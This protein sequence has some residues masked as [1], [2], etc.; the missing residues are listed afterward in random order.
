MQAREVELVMKAKANLADARA[1]MDLA[2]WLADRPATES[3][4][5]AAIVALA[6]ASDALDQA[7]PSAREAEL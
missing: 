2:Y 4:I 3:T 7:L 6:G 5:V 1:S